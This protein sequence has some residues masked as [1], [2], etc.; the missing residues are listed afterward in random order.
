MLDP[1]TAR[2][3]LVMDYVVQYVRENEIP[4][5]L[6]EIGKALEINSTNGVSDHLRVLERKGWIIRGMH[7]SRDIQLTPRAKVA[8]DLENPRSIALNEQRAL[9]KIVQFVRELPADVVAAIERTETPMQGGMVM[10]DTIREVLE[11][12]L[13]RIRRHRYEDADQEGSRG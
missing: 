4:P 3:Q 11:K 7:R 10:L 13:G 12:D 6:R 9:A 8:L 2:Q 5:T 1:L